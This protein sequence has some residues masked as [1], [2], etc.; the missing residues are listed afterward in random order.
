MTQEG[1]FLKLVPENDIGMPA[2]FT[3]ADFGF[4][5]RVTKDK[6]EVAMGGTW[7]KFEWRSKAV[8]LEREYVL[9]EFWALFV[10]D[11]P[12][13]SEGCR[14]LIKEPHRDILKHKSSLPPCSVGLLLLS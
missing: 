5:W 6:I 12:F 13:C 3:N 10:D 2:E 4:V 9:R 7:T 8:A 1:M 11:R 14:H